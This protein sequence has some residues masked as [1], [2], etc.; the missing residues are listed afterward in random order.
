MAVGPRGALGARAAS[1]T[2]RLTSYRHCAGETFGFVSSCWSGRAQ[3][4]LARFV[5]P[6]SVRQNIVGCILPPKKRTSELSSLAATL[7]H[8]SDFVLQGAILERCVRNEWRPGFRPQLCPPGQLP[9][10][11][12]ITSMR[13]NLRLW[14]RFHALL[15]VAVECRGRRP[16]SVC[17]S[18]LSNQPVP[19]IYIPA[20][21][22]LH[23]ILIILHSMVAT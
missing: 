17:S 1:R 12:R 11:S 22:I 13:S 7:R 4:G 16:D 9:T 18:G 2:Q 6:R 20:L 10:G 8:M 19:I 21:I 15:R 5:W 14:Q 3:L 23:S